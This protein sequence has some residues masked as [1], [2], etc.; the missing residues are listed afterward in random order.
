MHVAVDLGFLQ[1]AHCSTEIFPR[2]IRAAGL[3]S[4][5]PPA[6]LGTADFWLLTTFE[7]VCMFVMA[8]GLD[9]A[10]ATD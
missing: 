7:G 10:A 2:E 9:T 1:D 8:D 6:K 4:G 3:Y 5:K